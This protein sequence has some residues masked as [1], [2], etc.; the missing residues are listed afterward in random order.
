MATY[1]TKWMSLY[2]NDV[3]WYDN[4]DDL[5]AEL[6]KATNDDYLGD[7]PVELNNHDL[8]IKVYKIP[9]GQKGKEVTINIVVET[10]WTFKDE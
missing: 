4:R 2:N 7:V 9:P 1:K 5:T 6:Q 10:K 8:D 3:A